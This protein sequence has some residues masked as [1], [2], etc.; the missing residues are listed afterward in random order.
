MAVNIAALLPKPIEVEV[1]PGNMLVLKPLTLEQMVTL[2]IDN[3]RLFLIMYS[4]FE[5]GSTMEAKVG[6][7][8]VTAPEFI[9]R[10]IAMAADAEGQEDDIKRL[11]P[12]VQLIAVH[13][14]WKASVPDPKKAKE[15]LSEVM[16]QLRKASSAA[17]PTSSNLAN[18]PS[19]SAAN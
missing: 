8:L 17:S 11:P 18:L 14:L 4:Q 9:A 7:M 19:E 12:T 3:Q 5:S 1:S 15:L 16:A 6:T 10:L 13:E 2:L